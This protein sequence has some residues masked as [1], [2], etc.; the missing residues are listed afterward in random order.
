MASTFFAGPV[1]FRLTGLRPHRRHDLVSNAN[2]FRIR[3]DASNSDGR[4]WHW[5]LRISPKGKFTTTD[6]AERAAVFTSEAAA[7]EIIAQ[8]HAKN[9]AKLARASVNYL[10]SVTV[11]TF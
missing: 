2:S 8:W 10:N 7:R 1:V 6:R 4:A 9:D 11:E 3:F 5:Y